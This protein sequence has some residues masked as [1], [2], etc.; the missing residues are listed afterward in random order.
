MV[1]NVGELRKSIPK[2]S[3]PEM[4]IFRWISGNTFKNENILG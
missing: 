1:M 2:T 4:R 3:G